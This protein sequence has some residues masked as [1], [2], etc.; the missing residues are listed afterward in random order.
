[1]KKYIPKKIK[2]SKK[3]YKD[4][5]NRV[6]N[7]FYSN[8]EICYLERCILAYILELPD[9]DRIDEAINKGLKEKVLMRVFR[10]NEMQFILAPA[11]P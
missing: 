8:G 4:F 5:I 9:D 10:I 7:E 3:Y 11:I 1:M 2:L 6:T